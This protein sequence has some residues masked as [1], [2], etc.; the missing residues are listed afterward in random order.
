MKENFNFWPLSGLL[1]VGGGVPDTSKE[2]GFYQ[3]LQ[4]K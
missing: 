4:D 1:Y 2:S 3:W